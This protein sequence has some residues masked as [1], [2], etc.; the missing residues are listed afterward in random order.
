MAASSSAVASFRPLQHTPFTLV[1][2]SLLLL[3]MALLAC[4][5]SLWRYDIILYFLK[6]VCIR[7][8][9]HTFWT[10]SWYIYT[11]TPHLFWFALRYYFYWWRQLYKFIS[12]ISVSISF[13]NNIVI[14][15]TR[16]FVLHFFAL[17]IRTRPSFLF[18]IYV[19]PVIV[20]LVFVLLVLPRVLVQPFCQTLHLHCW[21]Y[22]L[23]L[24][25]EGVWVVLL[26]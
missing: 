14:L 19:K 7:Y 3:L 11:N 1:W 6:Y 9:F 12:I 23:V 26:V 2:H 10:P 5:V 22:G 24:N 15:G 25:H 13:L 16:F 8:N 20:S 4:A 18:F 17:P 21:R